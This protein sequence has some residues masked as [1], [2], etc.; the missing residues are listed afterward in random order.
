[1][2]GMGRS[3]GYDKAITICVVMFLLKTS[4]D[5]GLKVT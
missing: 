3:D 5:C 2:A 4:L 1:M